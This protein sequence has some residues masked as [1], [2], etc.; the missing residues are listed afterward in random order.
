VLTVVLSLIV[1][2][3][4]LA[5]L[6]RALE[7]QLVFFPSAGEDRTPAALGIRYET[8]H[9]QTSDGERLVAWQLEPDLPIADVVYFHGNGGNLSVWLPILATLHQLNLRVLAVDYRGYGLSSGSP[10]EQGLY[11]DAAAA[12]AHV[13][14]HRTAGVR[15]PLVYWGRSLGGAVAA[16]AA[17]VHVPDGLILESTF[18]DKAAVVKANPVLRTLNL[19]S[20][21]RFPTASLLDN[22]P[23]P[24]LVMHAAGDSIVSYALGRQLYEQLSPPKRFADIGD[25]DHNDLFEATRLTYWGPV[26]QFIGELAKR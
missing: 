1:G 11:R 19:F 14:G 12:V 5:L 6:V 16:S 13:V 2:A 15:A 25:A 22:V 4:V 17:R 24:K 23:V 9:L 7:P 18:A 10:S 3:L 8:V 20:R 26:L 21:Y